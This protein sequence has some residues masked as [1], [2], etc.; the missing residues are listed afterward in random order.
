LHGGWITGPASNPLSFLN[1]PAYRTS[2]SVAP[3]DIPDFRPASR[4]NTALPQWISFAVEERFRF[5]SY[6]NGGFKPDNSDSYMLNRF[7][8]QMDIEPTSWFKLSAQVQD[9]RPL[10][11]KP[12][13]GPPNQNTWN[14]KLAYVEFGDAEK[15]WISIRVGRQ[16]INYNNTLMAN[17][18]WRNQGRSYDAVAVN[19]QHERYHLG[20]FAASVV[21]PL[22]SGFSHH[23]QGNNI[24][25]TYGAIDNP[26]PNSRLEPFALWRVQPNVA[27]ETTAGIKTG[28]QDEKVYGTRFK[29]RIAEKFDYSLEV[30]LE[31]GSAGSND[32]HALGTTFGA[33]YQIASARWRPR[34]FGQYDFASGD[35]APAD[36]IHGTFD[37]I[38]PTAHDRLGIADQIGWQNIKSLRGG[39]T[40]EPR[41]RW[42]VT[43]QYLNFW[44]AS[45]TDALY[46]SSGGAVVRDLTGKSGMHVGEEFDAYTW[47]ELNRHLNV[48]V[49]VGHLMPGTFLSA[50]TRSRAYTTPYFAINFKDNGKSR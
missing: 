44:L 41:H 35:H 6:R 24:Y 37:T 16:L 20:I 7:R 42:S 23:Q 15:H 10:L 13:Y 12:P 9:A 38:Y 50:M 49:G 21:V 48:G 43:A 46:N 25:G 11:Q 28:R 22:A 27:I 31:R 3:Y 18:E 39:A 14:L 47:Y 1:G 4:L 40:I 17:S 33:G 34:L 32:I 29:G 45:P 2:R 30:V 19:L 5:E 26:I 36:G 8:Y